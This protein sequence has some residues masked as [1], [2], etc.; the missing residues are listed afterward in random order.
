LVCLLSILTLS[1]PLWAQQSGDD[2]VVDYNNPKKYTV[3]GVKVEGNQHIS[4]DQILQIASL[5]EGMEVTVPSEELS[6]VVN[7]LWM[8]RFEQR[9]TQN[10]IV[11]NRKLKHSS[12]SVRRKQKLA[13]TSRSRPP[14]QK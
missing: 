10:V 4:P 7:R 6:N 13:V 8:Q 2:V 12:S 3:G 9:Q 11:R 5:R 14:P 1:C